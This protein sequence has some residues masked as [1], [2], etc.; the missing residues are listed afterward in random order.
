M[1]ESGEESVGETGRPPED[2]WP[3][4]HRAYD[5][6][7]SSYQIMV[8]RIDAA[9]NRLQSLLTFSA[10]IAVGVP[11]VAK[12]IRP[13]LNTDSP[14]VLGA[15]AVF[16]IIA[17][18]GILGR[19]QGKVRVLDPG[20]FYEKWLHHDEWTFR[21]NMVYFSAQHFSLNGITLAKKARYSDWMACAFAVMV[22]LLAA[23]MGGW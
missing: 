5:F 14:L 19:I 18:L 12:S 8:S 1:I 10:T 22:I 17:A 13:G 3:G 6:V 20:V 15:L 11:A 21:K 7:V 2:Q 16:L 9:D 23:W 4:V